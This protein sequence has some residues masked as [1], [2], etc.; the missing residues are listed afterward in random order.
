MRSNTS[1]VLTLGMVATMAIACGGDSA[2]P[3]P[4]EV[5]GNWAGN[6][7]GNAGSFAVLITLQ[8]DAQ[9]IS[10]TGGISGSGPMCSMAI[11]GSRQGTR[12]NLTLTCAGFTPFTFEGRETSPSY[13]DG[14]F[15]GLE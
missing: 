6:G 2:G 12:V 11:L 9:G 10:G 5:D 13:I 4:Y 3:S 1:V 8:E 7:G 15:G 14:T